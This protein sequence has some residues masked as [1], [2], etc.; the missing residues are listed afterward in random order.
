MEQLND[1]QK[2]IFNKYL[3]K[4]N[5]FISGPGGSG[6]SYIIK[7]IYNHAEKNNKKIKVCALTGCAAI[8]LKCKATTIHSF[9]GIGIANKSIEE[10][11]KNVI[12]NKQ[13]YKNWK[14][15]ELLIIDE[16]SMLSLK[17]FLVLDNICKKIFNNKMTPF[18]GLQIIFSGDFYQL[19]PVY[20]KN[21]DIN[22]K[23]FCFEHQL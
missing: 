11:T 21:D 13:K 14:N 3:N 12:E 19:P 18:G 1:L 22:S 15:L 9:S 20:N 17:I 7:Y 23:L 4:E 10:I 5:I 16:V 6:K 8:L 2:I